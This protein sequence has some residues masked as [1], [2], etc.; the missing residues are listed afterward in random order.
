MNRAA[1]NI[2]APFGHEDHSGRTVAIWSGSAIMA[3]RGGVEFLEFP[4]QEV[5]CEVRTFM[6]SPQSRRT[7]LGDVAKLSA[8]LALRSPLAALFASPSASSRA[9]DGRL[10]G[11]VIP[12]ESRELLFADPDHER[13]IGWAD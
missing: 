3:K 8:A 12:S 7:M 5:F 2:I 13:L 11:S 6:R 1:Q 4:A 9:L 10:T